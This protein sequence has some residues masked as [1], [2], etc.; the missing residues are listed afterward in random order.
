MKTENGTNMF[1]ENDD[2]TDEERDDEN[3]GITDEKRMIS[4]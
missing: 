4:I 2:E 1:K 3:D